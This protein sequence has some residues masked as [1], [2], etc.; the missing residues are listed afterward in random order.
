[1]TDQESV[2]LV[3]TADVVATVIVT[4]A[5]LTGEDPLGIA[6]YRKPQSKA[7]HYAF[8]ALKKCF[9][10]YPQDRLAHFVGCAGKP[11]YYSVNSTNGMALFVGGPYAGQRRHRFW[12]EVIFEKVISAARSAAPLDLPEFIPAKQQPGF[13]TRDLPANRPPTFSRP[14]AAPGKR[15]LLEDLQR[16]VLNTGGKLIGEGESGQS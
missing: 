13:V 7:L 15:K 16:A 10:K 3:L 4:A 8:Q 11:E 1:M 12:D 2:R 6:L 14:V 9:P 5:K